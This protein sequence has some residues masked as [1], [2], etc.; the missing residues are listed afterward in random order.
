MAVLN[1]TDGKRQQQHKARLN[2]ERGLPCGLFK[3]G[4]C[5]TA[6]LKNRSQMY[7]LA[8]F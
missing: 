5:F 6:Y 1:Q 4:Q 7:H 3:A 8:M 2:E